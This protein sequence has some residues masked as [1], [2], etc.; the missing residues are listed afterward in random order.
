MCWN[1]RDCFGLLIETNLA[2]EFNSFNS[3]HRERGTTILPAKGLMY[4]HIVVQLIQRLYSWLLKLEDTLT[5]NMSELN[6][7]HVTKHSLHLVTSHKPMST[8]FWEEFLDLANR[9]KIQHGKTWLT[10]FTTSEVRVGIT[11][12]QHCHTEQFS[13]ASLTDRIFP[14]Y[15]FWK[16]VKMAN[17][18]MKAK[19]LSPG[20]GRTILR[21]GGSLGAS[22]FVSASS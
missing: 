1:V 2:T 16:P 18:L 7:T 12:K 17:N 4:R 14:W 15:V 22:A 10:I 9:R 13:I 19:T 11:I 20:F 21:F 6:V 5:R 8:A 3:E